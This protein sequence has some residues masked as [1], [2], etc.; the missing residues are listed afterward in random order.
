MAGYK[1]KI[2]IFQNICINHLEYTKARQNAFM[3]TKLKIKEIGDSLSKLMM[4][5]H[6]AKTF[7]SKHIKITG[8]TKMQLS[9]QPCSKPRKQKSPAQ[10]E[11]GFPQREEQMGTTAGD[12]E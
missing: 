5:E 12:W 9:V 1:I 3:K 7:C 11:K 4:I 10:K 8:N 6:L 2:S